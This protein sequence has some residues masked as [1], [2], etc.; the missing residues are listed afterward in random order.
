MLRAAFALSFGLLAVAGLKAQPAAQTA[1]QL[2]S[3]ISSLLPH[4]T[5]SSLDLVNRSALPPSEWSS[6]R[7]QLDAGLRK[8]GVN[9]GAPG[10][11]EPPLRVT[12]TESARGML[13]VAEIG[14]GDARQ[15]AIIPWNPPAAQDQPRIILTKQLLW[16][17]PEPILDVLVLDS[18][19]RMLV[20]SPNKITSYR[21]AGSAWMPNAS[22]SLVL[23]RPIPRDPRGRLEAAPG[24]FRAYLP[25]ATCT[26]AL[27]PDPSVTCAADN[28]TW[29]D[30]QVRWVSDRNLLEST[31][32]KGQFYTIANGLIAAA[33]GHVEDAAGQPIAGTESW[34]SDL[35]AVD[36]ACGSTIIASSASTDHDSV[37][38]FE[39]TIPASDPVAL[40]GP[41]TALWPAETRGQAT[42]VVH[43]LQ[44]GE[45]EAY[46][47]G[48]ACAQ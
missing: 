14:S 5:I 2:A 28:E 25:G 15:V 31:S 18:S 35:A 8:A 44:T 30:A 10:S 27:Q 40:P 11:P 37:R 19:S 6:F 22:A 41:E 43:N 32:A 39:N 20:L 47:L 33:D 34:G 23:P 42:L 38:A 1:T 26:G 9:V 46:R 7:S 48:F 12:L 16:M 3:R 45:Y 24:G 36:S 4:R 13:L 17:Q 21:L 29:P